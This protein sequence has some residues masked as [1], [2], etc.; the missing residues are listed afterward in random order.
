MDKMAASHVTPQLEVAPNKPAPRSVQHGTGESRAKIHESG[1]IA[2][3]MSVADVAEDAAEIRGKSV[4]T[5]ESFS[6]SV[7]DA[8]E[9]LNETLSRK[10]TSAQIRH[11]ADLNRYLVTIKDKDSGEIVREIPDEALLKLARN[12]QEVK[13]ILFD[14]LT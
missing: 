6:E 14:E 9:V 4:R 7:R 1:P 10:R 12:L 13:G 2:P 11:D 5:L 3:K 8:V